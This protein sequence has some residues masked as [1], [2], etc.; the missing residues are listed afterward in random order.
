MA[1]LIDKHVLP[2]LL[3]QSVQARAEE[4]TSAVREASDRLLCWS[5]SPALHR[6]IVRTVVMK[7]IVASW[8]IHSSSSLARLVQ[9]VGVS[10]RQFD[11][12]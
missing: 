4:N 9:H 3:L 2:P 11:D 8:D 6:V 7:H 10:F 12:V 1:T 5:I